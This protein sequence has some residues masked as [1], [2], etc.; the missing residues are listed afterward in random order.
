MHA[1]SLGAQ[2]GPASPGF[3][4]ASMHLVYAGYA[5]GQQLVAAVSMHVVHAGNFE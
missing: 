2:A 5:V 1:E 4:A 3:W